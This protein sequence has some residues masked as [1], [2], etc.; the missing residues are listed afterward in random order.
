MTPED[1]KAELMAA[2]SLF[3]NLSPVLENIM[4]S[5]IDKLNVKR[6]EAETK[7]KALLNS[8]QRENG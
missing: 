8:I 1:A 2:A 3:S 4:E 7:A 5:L 6:S